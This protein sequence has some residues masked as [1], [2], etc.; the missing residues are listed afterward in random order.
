MNLFLDYHT[1]CLLT[2]SFSFPG[3]T[4]AKETIQTLIVSISAVRVHVFLKQTF[5]QPA[6]TCI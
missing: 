2:S 3:N 4:E 5:L 1:F 6:I